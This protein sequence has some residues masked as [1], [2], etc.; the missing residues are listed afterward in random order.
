MCDGEEWGVLQ[1]QRQRDPKSPKR[2][3]D[4]QKCRRYGTVKYGTLYNSIHF[5]RYLADCGYQLVDYVVVYGYTSQL[6]E[7]QKAG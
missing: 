5:S 2:D 1:R 6:D 4:T 7:E 3:R